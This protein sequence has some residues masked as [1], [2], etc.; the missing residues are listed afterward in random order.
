MLKESEE[1]VLSRVEAK[2]PTLL[3]GVFPPPCMQRG[4]ACREARQTLSEVMRPLSVL[5]LKEAWGPCYRYGKDGEEGTP[6]PCFMFYVPSPPEINT[7]GR[8]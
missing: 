5:P 4:F 2:R 3:P 1:I 7:I 6:Q 8:L